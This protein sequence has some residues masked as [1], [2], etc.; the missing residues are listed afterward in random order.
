VRNII[1]HPEV[2][3][4]ERFHTSETSPIRDTWTCGLWLLEMLLL[5]LFR[6]SGSYSDRRD[7]MK[8]V[9]YVKPV[10]WSESANSF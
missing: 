3:L 2:K 6:Y 1:V 8:Y 9:G 5:R 7:P 10:P 4:R